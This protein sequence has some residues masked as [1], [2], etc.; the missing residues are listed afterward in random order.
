VQS[1]ALSIVKTVTR[2]IV[3]YRRN[4]I[5][6]IPHWVDD[7]RFK[8][9]ENL[10]LEINSLLEKVNRL[11]SQL[12]SWRDYKSILTTSGS[13]LRNK[14]VA[15]LENV[16]DLKVDLGE[17]STSATIMFDEQ[18]PAGVIDTQSMEG[19]PDENSITGTERLCQRRGFPETMPA[20]LFANDHSVVHEVSKRAQAEVPRDL[21]SYAKKK[22]ILILRTIDLL[23]LMQE[24]ES[25]TYRK[26]KLMHLLLSGGGCLEADGA[27]HKIVPE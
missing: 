19:E 8:S 2:S 26:T 6:E 22:N 11:E 17:D 7:M 27:H 10:Y 4:R 3:D 5:V 23:F 12:F 18:H 13:A 16:F 14:I 24:L 21:A 20:V 15:I 1:D 25:N 9:E